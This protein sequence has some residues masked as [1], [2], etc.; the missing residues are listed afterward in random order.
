MSQMMAAG[1]SPGIANF[2]AALDGRSSFSEP[3]ASFPAGFDPN[4]VSS[5][6]CESNLFSK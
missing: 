6:T 5:R 2:N 4:S 3:N 1:G